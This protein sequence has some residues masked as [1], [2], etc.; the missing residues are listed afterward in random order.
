MIISF[1]VNMQCI[2]DA[3]ITLV[4]TIYFIILVYLK[5][6]YRDNVVLPCSGKTCHC[7]LAFHEKDCSV[8]KQ[9][10]NVQEVSPNLYTVVCLQDCPGRRIVLGKLGCNDKK[11][12]SIT[13]TPPL[14]NLHMHIHVNGFFAVL[15]TTH[16]FIFILHRDCFDYDMCRCDDLCGPLA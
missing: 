4:K 8:N 12:P 7:L 2:C 10:M 14:L 11:N 13:I 1:V 6:Q 16:I 5:K 3:N 9:V 15:S